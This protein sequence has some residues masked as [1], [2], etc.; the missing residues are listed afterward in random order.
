ML[1]LCATLSL[2]YLRR[3]WYYALL[4]VASIAS[5]VSLLVATRDINQT[6]ARAAQAGAT[7]MSGAADFLVTNGETPVDGKLAEKLAKVPGVLTARPRIFENV[8][9]K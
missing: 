3:R 1:S 8:D 4:I 5:G 6:M 2:R 9:I 7:P